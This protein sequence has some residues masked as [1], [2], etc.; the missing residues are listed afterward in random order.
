MSKPNVPHP[1]P[2]LESK[3]P[4]LQ[5]SPIGIMVT[6]IMFLIIILLVS[7][8]EL[9]EIREDY[10]NFKYKVEKGD[11]FENGVTLGRIELFTGQ[12]ICRQIPLQGVEI[13]LE[14]KTRKEIEAILPYLQQ[15]NI[16]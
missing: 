5:K 4:N 13:K 6:A 8:I 9:V 7:T 16:K 15:S 2:V 10:E 1:P 12:V 3:E 11:N 14:C